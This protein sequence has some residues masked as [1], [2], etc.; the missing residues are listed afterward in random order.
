MTSQHYCSLGIVSRE[1]LIFGPIPYTEQ[2][3]RAAIP[4]L[5]LTSLA[6]CGGS[7]REMGSVGEVAN[8]GPG[9][10]QQVEPAP[11]SLTL[12]QVFGDDDSDQR[13]LLSGAFNVAVDDQGNLYVLNLFEGRLVAFA[14]DGS[15][16]W[17]V[18]APGQGPGEI[19]NPDQVIFDH[20]R[21]ELGFSNQSAARIDRFDTDGRHIGSIPLESAGIGRGNLV[22]VTDSGILVLSQALRNGSAGA[23]IVLIQEGAAADSFSVDVT[24]GMAVPSGLAVPPRVAVSGPEIVIKHLARYAYSFHSTEGTRRLTVSRDVPYQPPVIREIEG[25]VQM[26]N[27]TRQYGPLPLPDGRWL[28]GGLWPIDMGD[29]Q[30][31][32][33]LRDQGL[34]PELTFAHTMDLFASDGTLLYSLES[35]SLE[36]LDIQSVLAVD[37]HGRLYARLASGPLVGRFVVEANNP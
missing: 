13:G 28:G 36:A 29:P 4:F 24:E 30:A 3:M 8:R 26:T 15:V 33:A 17:E 32:M 10:W 35:E 7:P 5:L 18:E 25:G 11:L 14:P 2:H 21:R 22:G 34:A 23:R 20:L 37:V 19:H 31:H 27:W 6:A 1:T 16:R 9:V 12:E